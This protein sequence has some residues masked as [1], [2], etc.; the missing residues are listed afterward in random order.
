MKLPFMAFHSLKYVGL[1]QGVHVSLN[2]HSFQQT[3]SIV[4]TDYNAIFG[5]KHDVSLFMIKQ[6]RL[7]LLMY[8]VAYI[9][10]SL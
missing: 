5:E 2:S 6:K 9:W 7:R 1:P 4:G 10:T 8:E 3:P